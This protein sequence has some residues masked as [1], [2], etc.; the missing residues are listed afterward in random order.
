M[1]EEK[2]RRYEVL[3]DT[4]VRA[5]ARF[6]TAPDWLIRDT[7]PVLGIDGVDGVDGVDTIENKLCWEGPGRGPRPDPD[8]DHVPIPIGTCP[9]P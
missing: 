1:A 3:V 9:W 4:I 6:D 2:L 8:P 5:R 7:T